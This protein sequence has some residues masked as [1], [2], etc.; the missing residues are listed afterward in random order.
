MTSKYDRLA[1]H[2]AALDAPVVTLTL[3]EIEAV[4]G[5]LPPA[6]RHQSGWW[7]ETPSEGR[8]YPHGLRHM[9]LH[10]YRQ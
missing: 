3:G 8:W 5:S 7:G 10:A 6:A 1:D 9:M 4:I 2:L